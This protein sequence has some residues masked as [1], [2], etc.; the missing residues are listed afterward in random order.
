MAGA[1]VSLDSLCARQPSKSTVGA[2]E[3]VRGRTKEREK[4][5]KKQKSAC[6]RRSD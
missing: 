5:K 3:N 6:V 1:T 4:A 2:E